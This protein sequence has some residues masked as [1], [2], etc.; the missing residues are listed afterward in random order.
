M[1][2]VFQIERKPVG[3]GCPAFITAEIGLNHDGKPEV[4]RELIRAAAG[5]GV[6]AVKFQVFRAESFISG[7]IDR[8]KHQKTAL[9]SDET[10]FEMWKRLE[11]PPAELGKLCDYARSMGLVFYASA[12]DGESVEILNGLRVGA[13]KIASGEV[14]N[15]PLIKTV[16][17][18]ERPIIMS[19]GMAS[20]GEIEEAV[21]VIRAAGNE[22]LALMHCVANYPAEPADVHLRRIAKLQQVFGLPVGYSDHTASPW[23]CIASVAFGASFIEKHFTLDKNRPGTDHALSA[24]AAEMGEIVRG[25]RFTEAALG[26]EEL[27]LLETEREGR[28]LFRRGLVAVRDIPAGTVITAEMIAAKRPASGIQ[29]K[30]VDLVVGRRASRDIPNG[31]PIGWGDV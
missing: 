24:D 10:V 18:G 20:L 4:A 26:K 22:E 1:K 23:A 27:G 13:F 28:T 16:A 12:F 3:C 21:G 11:L 25:I 5:A 6:D 30:H 19:V 8:A 29:P 15:L 9:G 2:N 17:E 31:A 14:T 7:D